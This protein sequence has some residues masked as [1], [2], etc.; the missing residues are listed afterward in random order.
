VIPA[1]VSS[2]PVHPNAGNLLRVVH[3]WCS[4]RLASTVQLA[5][6]RVVLPWRVV[7]AIQ[8]ARDIR[9]SALVL[10]LQRYGHVLA[11]DHGLT[12]IAHAP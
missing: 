3:S 4:P 2:A 1:I 6:R 12:V 7:R 5:G 8:A 11:D 10:E 9:L